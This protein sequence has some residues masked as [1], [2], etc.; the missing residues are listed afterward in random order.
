MRMRRLA[1]YSTA[2]TF[3]GSALLAGPV[4]TVAANYD[5]ANVSVYATDVDLDGAGDIEAAIENDTASTP[6]NVL[7]GDSLIVAID[8]ERLA[9]EID[10]ANGPTTTERF[11]AVLEGDPELLIRQTNALQQYG[12][13]VFRLGPANTTVY[14]SGNTTYAVI[15]TGTVDVD[16]HDSNESVDAEINR[17]DVYQIQFGTDLSMTREE[18]SEFRTIDVEAEF[19]DGVFDPLAP[20]IVNRTVRT[21]IEPDEELV[22]TLSLDG[23]ETRSERMVVSDG[24][25]GKRSVDSHVEFDLR[26]VDS[27]TEYTLELVHDGTVVD[28]RNGTVLEPNATLTGARFVEIAGERHLTFTVRLSHG[29]TVVT[30]TLDGERRA[31]VD[32]IAPGE[33]TEVEIPVQEDYLDDPDAKARLVPERGHVRAFRTGGPTVT[34]YPNAAYAIDGEEI[35]RGTLTPTPTATPTPAASASPTGTTTA[36]SPDNPND[37]PGFGTMITVV[38]LA[39]AAL[40]FLARRQLNTD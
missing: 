30:E 34:A 14:R 35:H 10:E 31:V 22:V 24:D 25:S 32:G 15:D 3:V 39:V 33:S 5:D 4:T 12:A 36:G 8:S 27:G 29:G 37:Q 20:D 26:E 7:I 21:Y 19:D 17:G 16:R 18:G 38:A 40:V 2:V 28:R 11:F 23:G 9:E 13:K 6:Q 1:L